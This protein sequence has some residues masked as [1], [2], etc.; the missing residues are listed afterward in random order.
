MPLR[1]PSPLALVPFLP[2]LLA[3]FAPLSATP[4]QPWQKITHPTASEAAAIFRAPPPEYSGQFTW[5]WSGPVDHAVIA[6]DLDDMKALGVQ[7]AIIEPKS[8]NLHPYLSPEWFDLVKDAV[9]EAKKRN[10]R[11]WI[12]DDGDYPSGLSGGKFTEERPDLRMQALAPT[13]RVKVPAGT[14]FTRD[15]DAMTICAVAVES[16]SQKTEVLDLKSGK[17]SWTAPATGDWEIALGHAIFR[18]G[19]TRSANNPTGAKDNLHSLMDYLNP[20]ATALFKKWNFDSY[21]KV[22][23]GELGKTVL[24]FRGDEPAYNFEPWTPKLFAEFEKRKGYDLRPYLVGFATATKVARNPDLTA[25]QRRAYADFCDVWS[26]LF[27]E[28][29][30]DLEAKWCADHGVEMQLHVEHEEILPQLA[31]SNGDYFK[32]FRHIQVPGVDIIWHQLW[33][34]NPANFPKLASSAAHLYGFPRSMTEAFAAYQPPPNLKQARWLLDFLMSRGITRIEYMFFSASTPRPSPSPEAAAKA[35]K[36]APAPNAPDSPGRAANAARAVRYYR[37]P[38]FP[39]VAGYVHRLSYLLGEGQPGASIGLYIPSSSFWLGDENA[40]RQI[41]ESVLKISRELIE[42]QRDFDF[43]DEQ[44]LSTSVL[45]LKDGELLNLSGQGYRA[46][47]IPPAL[48]ISK[49]AL[50]KL[51]KFAKAGGQVIFLGDAPASVSD[52]NFLHAQGPADVSWAALHEPTATVTPAVL[53]KLPAPDFAL[54][55]PSTFVSYQHRRLKDADVY[56]IFNSGDDAVS[57]TASLAG[58]GQAQLWNAD[59]GEV[60][61]LAGAKSLRTLTEVPLELAPWST[62]VIVIGK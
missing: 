19:P 62:K 17:L 37:D 46:I 44:A 4:N 15:V 11:L 18:S 6:R 20:E 7:A 58:S 8:G 56:F 26:D 24:G 33:M 60:T 10:M 30:F 14:T 53:G 13:E 51:Q 45:T 43:V 25:E 38:G 35:A 61:P 3:A 16:A 41:N 28:N 12:M 49:A 57:T 27:S 32:N 40:S 36:A 42:Q 52:K 5:G 2:L 9:A 31:L 39:A 23:E 21:E 48:A 34:D 50:E 55:K 29:Y 59:T 47:L 22:L 1:R 54:A